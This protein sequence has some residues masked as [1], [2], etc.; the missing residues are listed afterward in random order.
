MRTGTKD[1]KISKKEQISAV[2][3]KLPY[4]SGHGSRVTV[5]SAAVVEVHVP[6]AYM[7]L[8]ICDNVNKTN[9]FQNTN[10]N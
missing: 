1:M 3:S 5:P 2:P 4:A 6:S 7:A 9:R 8:K 10:T